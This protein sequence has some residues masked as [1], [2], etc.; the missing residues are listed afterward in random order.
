L[1]TGSKSRVACA[2]RG[3][4][5]NNSVPNASDARSLVEEIAM[6]SSTTTTSDLRDSNRE[7]KR[8][9]GLSMTAGVLGVLMFVWGFLRWFNVGD[10]ANGQHRYSGYAFQTPSVAVVG[11]SLA[12]GLMAAFGAMDRRRG[13]G[14]PTA[15]PTALAATSLLLGIAVALGK[16]AI[17]P[18]F[19]ATVG[20]EVGIYLAIATAAVQTIVLTMEM[21]SRHHERIDTHPDSG[22]QTGVR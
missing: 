19:G 15:V 10:Q 5:L 16:G 9:R 8:E 11:L 2:L 6:T 22:Y 21:R 7:L 12:A 4:L 18:T 20:L 13:R 1:G 14:V 17:S 3:G